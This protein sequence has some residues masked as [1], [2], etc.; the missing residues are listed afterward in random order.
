MPNLNRCRP[1]TATASTGRGRDC[2]RLNSR[3]IVRGGGGS[4]SHC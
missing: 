4:L 3:P 1:A 2:G